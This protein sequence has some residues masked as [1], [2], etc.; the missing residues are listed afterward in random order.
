[1]QQLEINAKETDAFCEELQQMEENI[2]DEYDDFSQNL[3]SKRRQQQEENAKDVLKNAKTIDEARRS[4]QEK[5]AVAAA[6]QEAAN[7]QLSEPKKVI[8]S[9]I[10]KINTKVIQPNTSAPTSISM[11]VTLDPNSKIKSLQNISN[12]TSLN[13][14]T[15]NG[16][17]SKSPINFQLDD[18]PHD[19]ELNKFLDD[20]FKPS[21]SGSTHINSKTDDE[22][23]DANANNPMVAAFKD[24]IDSSDEDSTKNKMSKIT[25]KQADLSDNDDEDEDNKSSLMTALAHKQ[26][27]KQQGEFVFVNNTL[28]SHNSTSS[29]QGS[30]TMASNQ[31]NLDSLSATTSIS[32]MNYDSTSQMSNSLPVQDDQANNFKLTNDDFEFLENM[33]LNEKISKKSSKKSNKN[34]EIKTKKKSRK[35]RKSQM[36]S[37]SKMAMMVRA[38]KRRR[39]RRR[40][41]AKSHL[42]LKVPRNKVVMMWKMTWMREVALVLRGTL[43]TRSSRHF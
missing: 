22:D 43:T 41:K 6:A 35:H 33:S 31:N 25:I 10:N 36:M 12:S 13:N 19:D 23:D 34:D 18:F 42:R 11:S 14:F 28:S 8:N 37:Y 29:G 20:P 3:N 2:E 9:I 7:A 15:S 1:M 21:S 26:E 24:T 32:M 40:K 27:A 17:G 39:R 30:T 38:R 5:E 16:T 4:A